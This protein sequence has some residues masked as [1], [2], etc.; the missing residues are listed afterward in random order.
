MQ[1]FQYFAPAS[2]DDVLELLR[3]HGPDAAL[4]AG[5][6]D[7]MVSMNQRE[8]SPKYIV[9]IRD[10][11]ELRFIRKEADCIRVGA[12]TTKAA[13]ASSEV[14]DSKAAAL[15]EAARKSSGPQVRNLATI[16]G[17]L[18][19]ASPAGDLVLA[20]VALDARL[21][22]RSSGGT[23]ELPVG[24]FLVGP[25]QNALATG[26]VITE[27]VVPISPARSG[28]AFQKLGKRKAMSIS[29]A[30]AAAAITVSADGLSFETVRVALGSIAPT[31]VRA[32]RFE[33]ALQGKPATIEEIAKARALVREDIS[34]ITDIRGQA[35]YRGEVAPVLAGRAVEDALAAARGQD[36]ASARMARRKRGKGI[37]GAIYSL[38]VPGFPN[39]SS[40]D[41]RM[42][43]DG[44][45]LL[46][47]GS[48]DIGQGSNTV[49]SQIAAEALG[50]PYEHVTI[51]SAD[52]GTTP[53]DMGT[54]SSRQTYAGGNA[55]LLAP[56]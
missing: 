30:S 28:S 1:L 44:S 23:R 50:V 53:F 7:L 13:L 4:M 49:L 35:W 36:F 21:K 48:V 25:K 46:L 34:P 43:E 47:M 5:G 22:I 24:E 29:V 17:N 51:E 16:G 56:A 15:A 33:Q 12:L 20:L 41:I 31:V 37:A 55:I 40:A 54:F 9:Q 18:G 52:T 10:L 42:R 32:H 2:V 11:P 8:I 27:I 3:R 38:T 19:T 39:P 45:V 14:I 6:T 26:E